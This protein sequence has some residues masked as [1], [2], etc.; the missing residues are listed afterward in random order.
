MTTS[1]INGGVSHAGSPP[2]HI[3]LHN[4]FDWVFSNP[5]ENESSFTPAEHRVPR[6]EPSRPIF[7]DQNAG[8]CANESL[9]LHRRGTTECKV[10]AGLLSK[11]R[12]EE[13]KEEKEQGSEQLQ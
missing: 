11:K 10:F 12:K 9:E 2:E 3:P 1:V 13:K 5:F 4:T 6:I 7:V 8:M